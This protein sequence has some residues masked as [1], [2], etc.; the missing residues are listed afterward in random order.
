MLSESE[1]EF[2]P[3]NEHIRSLTRQI[4]RR[5]CRVFLQRLSET[6]CTLAANLV[7]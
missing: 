7:I 2:S 5:D 6:L 3:A 1:H 4:N